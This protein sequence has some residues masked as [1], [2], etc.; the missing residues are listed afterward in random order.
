VVATTNDGVEYARHN[1]PFCIEDR[2]Q[3][4]WVIEGP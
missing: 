3:T 2:G 4:L 1:T